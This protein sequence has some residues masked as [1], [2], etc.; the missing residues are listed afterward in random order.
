MIL[1]RMRAWPL[2]FVEFHLAGVHPATVIARSK[3]PLA[4]PLLN[5]MARSLKAI[6]KVRCPAERF[7]QLAER[8]EPTCSALE[9][10][11][12][13][14]PFSVNFPYSQERLPKNPV[15]R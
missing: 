12:D 11:F 13:P 15:P 1:K 9:K 5:V 4:L 3:I 14:G 6:L 10:E 8:P 7:L 2:Y